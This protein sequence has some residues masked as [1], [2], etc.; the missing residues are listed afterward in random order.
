MENEKIP[1]KLI[2]K[3]A[4]VNITIGAGMIE[5]LV[6]VLSYFVKNIPSE[7]IDDYHKQLEDYQKISNKEKEFSEDWM[8]PV[9]TLSILLQ[10]VN[11]Q[12][13]LQNQTI[14]EEDLE[15]FLKNNIEDITNS[16]ES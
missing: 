8:Q 12:A 3:D 2:K 16:E 7:K 1:V 14:V 6:E 13:D 10:E 11:K 15:T 9:T 4:I 5:K